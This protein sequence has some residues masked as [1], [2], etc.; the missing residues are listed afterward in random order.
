MG[1]EVDRLQRHL[2]QAELLGCRRRET[3]PASRKRRPLSFSIPRVLLSLVPLFA[4]GRTC[5]D[6]S[7]VQQA[8]GQE[9]LVLARADLGAHQLRAGGQD[10]GVLLV[11]VDAGHRRHVVDVVVISGRG[12]RSEVRNRMDK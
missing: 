6:D 2:A 8:G 11:E 10:A 7:A 9:G 4:G 3:E 1:D 12:Q 5:I